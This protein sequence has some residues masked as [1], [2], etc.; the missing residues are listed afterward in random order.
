MAHRARFCSLREVATLA[1]AAQTIAATREPTATDR[2]PRVVIAIVDDG[3]HLVLFHRD[4]GSEVGSVE[5]ATLT[6]RTATRSFEFRTAS[7]S[8]EVP[9]FR[10]PTRNAATSAASEP[11]DRTGKRAP[12][13]H[14]FTANRGVETIGVQQA[15]SGPVRRDRYFRGL[16][17]QPR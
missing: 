3:G 2:G 14:H 11:P 6:A 4:D 1:T 17:N 8:T 7:R 13:G 12:P 5:I 9:S 16:L 10:S 15:M